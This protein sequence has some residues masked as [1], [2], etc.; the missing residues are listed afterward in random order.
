MEGVGANDGGGP[1]LAVLPFT[2][3][4]GGEEDAL[5]AQGL[6]E[7]LCGELTRFCSLGVISWVSTLAAADLPDA[8]VRARL[9]ASHVL[10]GRLRRVE[11]RLQLSASLGVAA[12]G[13]Q[14][15]SERFVV[16]ADDVF[17]L[18][19]EIVARIAA[20][21]HARIEESAL[22]EARRRPTGNLA[23]HALTLRGLALLREGTLA[24]D[25]EARALFHGALELDPLYARAHGGIA[26]SWFN[27][28][29]CAFWRQ[30]HENAQRAYA[31]AHRA[32]ELDDRDAM[33]HLVVGKVLLFRRA[34]E[35]ASWYFDRALALCPNDADLLIQ[36][37]FCE[38]LLGRPEVGVAHAAK[39]M[40][41]NPYH[42]NAYYIAAAIAH[43][44]AGDI[45]A[46]IACGARV[47]GVPLIDV[48]AY[49]A[50]ALALA[51]RLEEAHR[52]FAIYRDAFRERITFGREPQP[53]EAVRWMIEVNPYRRDQDATVLL[54]GFR[55]LGE[56]AA[57]PAAPMLP[58]LG[59]EAEPEA[60]GPALSRAGEGWV[61]DYEGRRV[62]LLDLK[63][64]ADI[65][66]LLQR[67]GEEVHCLDLAER[68]DDAYRGETVLD[69]AGR[70]ALKGR[71]R[72]LQE[73]LA[74][75]EDMNDPGR[76]E[77]A[78]GELDHLVEMLSKALGLGG[79]GRRLGD[80]AERARST[81]T[82][83]IRH[84]VKR[85]EAAHP[86][87]GRHFANSLR[88]GMFCVYRPERAVRWRLDGSA[89]MPMA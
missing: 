17:A 68:E 38:A 85:V 12:E 41:L 7:D 30:F 48:P 47:D 25:E 88:T 70:Q 60:T 74:E 79:R 6:H 86:E 11:G 19:D 16:P 10:R 36:L 50:V 65:R 63:G 81:V 40:R 80:A 15:W 22:S 13:T 5:L 28:W 43:L 23:A 59:D 72:D 45:E 89:T 67:P 83:R 64:L 66:R 8:E 33:L 61:V 31:H 32:L 77:R 75:A 84:A 76:A 14:I 27:E 18:Q 73:E 21:L 51:G 78:R 39:A 34:F 4:G 26:L 3:L 62:I 69:D 37:A 57:A 54:D 24:A 9:G 55:L 71:I 42:P 2:T 20:T 53:G 35:Q 87:L 29:S 44:H 1:V 56:T 52:Q 49:N 58:S 82:W 46:A